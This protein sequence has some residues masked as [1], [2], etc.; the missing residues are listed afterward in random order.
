MGLLL[1]GREE[2]V[3][4]SPHSLLVIFPVFQEQA[5]GTNAPLVPKTVLVQL[6]VEE[7]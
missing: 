6:S 4:S 1:S 2:I 5:A 7:E 3:G